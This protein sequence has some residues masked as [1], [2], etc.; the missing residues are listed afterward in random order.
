[1]RVL[2]DTNPLVS[3]LLK[4]KGVSGQIFSRWRAGL[5]ELAVSPSSLTELADVLR[6]PHIARK[7][8]IDESIIESHLNVL[9]N[10]AQIAFGNLVVDVVGEDP[11][12]NHVLAAALETHSTYI[13]T[14][15]RH[16]LNMTQCESIQTLTPRDFLPVLQADNLSEDDTTWQLIGIRVGYSR[17]EPLFKN[18]LSSTVMIFK[19]YWRSIA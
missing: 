13:V 11:K 15:D 2:L 6:R 17:S 12:D 14:G 1:V 5:F 18:D 3:A 9:R 8:P 7:Y 10:Y 19:R 4:P 16:L